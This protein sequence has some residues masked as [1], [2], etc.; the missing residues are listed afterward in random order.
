MSGEAASRADL[1]L[2]AG[3]RALAEA[4]LDLGKPVV[5]VLCS[6]RPLVVPWLFERA[7]AVLAGWFLGTQAGHAIADVLTGRWNPSGRLAVSWPRHGGQ[8]PIFYAQRPSGR[9]YRPGERFS[10]GYLDLPATPE[11][12]FGHGL[13]FSRF[14]LEDLQCMPQQVKAGESIEVS[15]TVHN[16]SLRRGETTVFLFVHDPIATV[17]RPVLELKGTHKAALEAGERCR[18]RWVLPAEALAFLGPDLEPVLESGRF[19][20]RVGQ[21]A[22]SAGLLCQS[23]E[24]VT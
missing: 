8:V 5:A 20:M 22:D 7:D 11:F 1:G 4:A 3:Q 23:I 13:S 24:L 15:V 6:G 9:P 18:L 2:P 17:T 16:D 12:P 14:A 19:E 10:S 21:S